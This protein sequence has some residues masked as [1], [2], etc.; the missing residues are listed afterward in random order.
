MAR[1]LKLS[2]PE[3]CSPAFQVAG[4]R[5]FARPGMSGPSHTACRIECSG[6]SRAGAPVAKLAQR[7]PQGRLEERGRVG[8]VKNP[9][10][11]VPCDRTDISAKRPV[12]GFAVAR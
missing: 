11:D 10:V 5:G 7:E 2:I 9:V 1:P 8:R 3:K 6:R 4:S 12:A